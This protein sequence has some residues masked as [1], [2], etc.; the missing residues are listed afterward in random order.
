MNGP[1]GPNFQ[2]QF[3]EVGFLPDAGLL[4]VISDASDRAV[5][6]INRNDTNFMLNGTVLTGR[7][8]APTTFQ[9]HFHH[10]WHV[11]G[12]SCQHQIFVDDLDFTASYHICSGDRTC[13]RFFNGD[14]FHLINALEPVKRG[15]YAGVVGYLDWSG[16]LDT[17]ICIRTMFVRADGTTA[18]LQA[19]AGVVADS[20]PEDEDLECHNKAAA[21]LAAIPAARRMGRR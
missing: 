21:L 15:P 4:N 10:K 8:I 3:V 13:F 9:N 1:I 18:S 16:N 14:H 17:A 7:H 5:D 6:R 11:I 12:Q 19:G 2:I 20:V